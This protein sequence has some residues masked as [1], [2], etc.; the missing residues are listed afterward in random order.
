MN[1]KG[2]PARFVMTCGC[3]CILCWRAI[4]FCHK[5]HKSASGKDNVLVITTILTQPL[6]SLTAWNC[7]RALA[8]SWLQFTCYPLLLLHGDYLS[9]FRFTYKPWSSPTTEK[10]SIH[11]RR[12]S[13]RLNEPG[14][15]HKKAQSCKVTLPGRLK[16]EGCFRTP[17]CVVCM[18]RIHDY[19]AFAF[20]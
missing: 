20:L 18:C 15:H 9:N 14:N 7:R 3:I 5:P 12:L 1:C 16:A 4:L 8:F 2:K 19:A 6:Y 10:P 13:K 17:R 11:K